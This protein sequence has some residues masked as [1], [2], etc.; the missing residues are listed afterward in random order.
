MFGLDNL[1]LNFEGFK[2]LLGFLD[3]S[4]EFVLDSLF[5]SFS[6]G[7]NFGGSLMI[8]S[9]DFVFGVD[10]LLGL[11]SDSSDGGGSEEWVAGG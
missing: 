5:F 10:E 2:L 1:E 8:I 9:A 3:L 11:S 4:F 6:F 7:V